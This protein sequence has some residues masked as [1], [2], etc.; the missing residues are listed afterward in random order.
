MGINLPKF[1]EKINLLNF[2]SI[3]IFFIAF[4]GFGCSIVLI[5]KAFFS[6]HLLDQRFCID[7]DCLHYIKE[8]WD[9]PIKLAKS[10][11]EIMVSTA[12][13]GGIFIALNSYISNLSNSA[14]ANHI[15]HFSIFNN[16]LNSEIL[17]HDKIHP[18]SINILSWYNNIFTLSRN[19]ST[20]VSKNYIQFINELNGQIKISNEQASQAKSGSFRYKDHQKRI[21]EN[22]KK[23]EIQL[24]YLPRNDFFEV[25]GEIYSLIQKVNS[26][27]CFT[28]EVPALEVRKYI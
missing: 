20:D 23:I 12:T 19:G 24:S 8:V 7:D 21:I 28:L 25:E 22:L 15:A 16:Y 11:T 27:F 1:S 14:L 4:I 18:Q 10:T 6:N 9:I 2:F 5:I 26:S 17:K 3:L 13:I